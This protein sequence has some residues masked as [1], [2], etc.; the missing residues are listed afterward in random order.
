MLI[1]GATTS[2]LHTALRIEPEYDAPV[3]HVL[4][5]SRA[6]TVVSN[7][8]SDD[9]IFKEKYLEGIK[10]DYEA[11]R[12]Q[13][14]KRNAER[15]K[16]SIEEARNNKFKIDWNSFVPCPPVQ[17][18]V[19]IYLLDLNIL[20]DYIDWT[21][22]FQ[23]WELAGEISC[24]LQD[25][26]VGVEA[27]KL[28]NDAKALLNKIVSEKLIQAKAEVGIFP[29]NS[30]GDDLILYNS[31]VRDHELIKLHH[32]RQQVKKA[33]GQANL[34]LS[35]FI[36]P[37]ESGK[38]DFVGAFAV[39]AG[40][41]VEE[42]VGEYER[43][44]DDY[45][46]IMVKAL[47]DRFAEAAAEYMHAKVRKEIWGYASDEMLD[48]DSLIKEKYAGVRPAPGYPACPDHTEKEILWSLLDVGNRIGIRLTESMAMFPAAS[49]S[50]WYFAHPESKYFGISEIHEDQLTDYCKRKNWEL[51]V[52]KKWLGPI[53]Q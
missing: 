44:H 26:V 4:D 11:V 28:F 50:G 45:H 32:L 29:A 40:F 43:A 19:N 49:V 9:L 30:L 12:Q 20:S 23:S 48:N 10:T 53:L 25:E 27:Q 51:S 37:V 15:E 5:A 3:V 24:I 42:L 1:G 35:D 38:K 13:R 16:I 36:A 22:F 52:G 39:S 21:P 17:S 34:C 33:S 8:L 31:D 14:M 7:L 18:G 2:K 47:A 41:G 6:V 46:A